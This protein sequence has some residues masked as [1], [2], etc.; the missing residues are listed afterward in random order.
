MGGKP[1]SH[2]CLPKYSFISFIMCIH[3]RIISTDVHTFVLCCRGKYYYTMLCINILI[4]KNFKSSLGIKTSLKWWRTLLAG[5]YLLNNNSMCT[6]L[7]AACWFLYLFH[8]VFLYICI[9]V[10]NK[11][12][13]DCCH[14]SAL[15]VSSLVL[16][17]II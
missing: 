1:F 15:F 13:Y 7:F 9:L 16:K 6:C 5:D 14:T 10:C 2:C 3:R 8:I 12:L 17:W 4:T 11:L